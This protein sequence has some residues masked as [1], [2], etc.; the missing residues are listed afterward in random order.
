MEQHPA[1]P[2][3]IGV[4]LGGTKIEALAIDAEGR[5]LA[6]RADRLARPRLRADDRGD[7]RPRR[8]D[9]GRP[10]HAGPGRH[11]H[12][13]RGLAGQRPDQERQLDRAQRPPARRRPGGGARP[14]GARRQ[15]R[16][17]LRPLRG[18]RRRRRRPAG[19]LRRHPR[20]RRRRRPGRRRP[21]LGRAERDR[22]RVG[23]QRAAV[24][25][26]GGL[27]DTRCY[28][29][30]RRCIETYLSGPGA[31]RRSRPRR[32]G[33][34]RPTPM[35]GGSSPSRR[36]GD[37]AGAGH[38]R[39]LLPAP[40]ERARHRDQ[41][42]RS[43]RHRPRRRPV[44]DRRALRRRCR[45]CSPSTSSPT[46]ATRRSC[47]TGTATPPACAA[48][49]GSGR[50]GKRDST[51]LARPMRLAESATALRAGR[52]HPARGEFRDPTVPPDRPLAARPGRHGAARRSPP[53]LPD[54][55]DQV[56]RAVPAGRHHRRAGAHRRAVADR[57]ARPAGRRRE[58]A[59]RAATTS[60]SRRRST[61]RPTATRC[62][63]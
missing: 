2:I 52:S 37:A 5:E 1:G 27:P 57:E 30:R 59:R 62:C 43:R 50:R 56:D 22:R 6:R 32:A 14:R 47:A 53:T 16:R 35:P 7:P 25:D 13:G 11:R 46:A 41:R 51:A 3:R 18:E 34:R 28:C 44:A 31:R 48:R 23:P 21:A 26:R 4:D 54:P 38:A 9:R 42:R 40:G 17:L 45:R 15:R 24:A 63:W 10:R 49:P 12:A 55:A 60:A 39:P 61:R 36:A 20:H 33:R 58:Q 29:G 19:R 8:R